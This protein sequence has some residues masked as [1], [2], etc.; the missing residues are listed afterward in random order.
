VG[1]AAD[2]VQALNIRQ[3]SIRS[4]HPENSIMTI[5]SETGQ[6]RKSVDPV[7]I[8]D[9]PRY[10][11]ATTPLELLNASREYNNKLYEIN[12]VF[13]NNIRYASEWTAPGHSAEAADKL[14]RALAIL[15]HKFAFAKASDFGTFTLSKILVK[16][17]T[18]IAEGEQKLATY[19]SFGNSLKDSPG[20]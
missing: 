4:I 14:E 20:P 10:W 18:Q 17:Q 13:E 16:A 1:G 9:S 2:Y 15:K 12:S 5:S 19:R 3:R 11:N 6:V 7:K 8:A